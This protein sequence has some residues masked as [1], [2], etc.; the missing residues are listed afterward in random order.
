MWV[1][2]YDTIQIEEKQYEA[3]LLSRG[4][5]PE[6]WHEGNEALGIISENSFSSL[7]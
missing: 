7:W 5:A 1:E 4:I 6:T 3:V 2:G